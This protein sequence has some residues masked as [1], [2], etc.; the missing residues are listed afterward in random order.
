[1]K[2]L[3]EILDNTTPHWPDECEHGQENFMFTLKETLIHDD[4]HESPRISDIHRMVEESRNFRRVAYC[5]RFGDEPWEYMST[6]TIEEFEA[7][8][9]KHNDGVYGFIAQELRKRGET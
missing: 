8:A 9:E 1:M 7:F 6:L 5:R 4:G 3:L 2:Q